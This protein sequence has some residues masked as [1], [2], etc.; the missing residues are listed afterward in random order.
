LQLRRVQEGS[1]AESMTR[2]ERLL[3]EL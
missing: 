1:E 3:S 2:M